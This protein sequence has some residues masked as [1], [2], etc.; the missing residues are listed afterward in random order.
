MNCLKCNHRNPGAVGYCQKC[1]A[2]MDFTADE[3]AEA[4]AEKGRSEVVKETGFHAKRLLTFAVVLFLAAV[5]FLVLSG[6]PPE[7]AYY[8]PSAANGSKYIQVEVVIDAE[9]SKPLCPLEVKRK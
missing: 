3:I 6:G 5:T 7:G 9:L 1:G 2:K 4:L 8:L